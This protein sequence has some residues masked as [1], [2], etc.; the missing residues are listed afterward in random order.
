MAAANVRVPGSRQAAFV[1]DLAVGDAPLLAQH[2]LGVKEYF[3]NYMVARQDR[4]H[5]WNSLD[6]PLEKAFLKDE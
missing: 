1:S 4:A 6:R 2:R 5:Y 3:H